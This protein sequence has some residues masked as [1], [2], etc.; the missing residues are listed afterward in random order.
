MFAEFEKNIHEQDQNG[1][2]L[3]CQKLCDLYYDL[4][5]K[6]FGNNVSIDEDIKY[7]WSRIP[8]FYYNFYVYQYATGYIAAL[9]IAS[10]IY[11]KKDNALDNYLKFLKLGCT[12]NPVESLKVAGVDLTKK[13]I[14]DLTFQEFA[15]EMDEFEK[16]T[17][18][19]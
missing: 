11:N 9:K 8:H 19:E 15:K 2:I 13:E 7:E 17:E 18:E 6:Y 3:T 16:L 1:N 14:F 10:D 5:K 4:N 12:I